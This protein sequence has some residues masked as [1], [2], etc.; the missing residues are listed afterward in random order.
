[1]ASYVADP[2][3]YWERRGGR[4]YPKTLKK[5]DIDAIPVQKMFLRNAVNRFQPRILM[6][7]GCG[8]GKHFDIWRDIPTVVA[9]DR[10]QSMISVS[11]ET[12]DHLRTGYS[13]V[14]GNSDHRDRLPFNGD[15]FDMI[16]AC[17]VFPHVLE[18]DISSLIAEFSRI[19]AKNGNIVAVVSPP[20]H[21]FQPHS[22][23]HDYKKLFPDNGFRIMH[24]VT[25][26]GYRF[27]MIEKEQ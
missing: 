2:D 3:S 20:D 19:M 10:S 9:Y 1:M 26:A 24:D 22:C 7:F 23:N 6:D 21:D 17:E 5:A 14:R 13:I 18:T 25:D 8:T 27:L 11:R 15:Q 16:V 4:D 12:Q